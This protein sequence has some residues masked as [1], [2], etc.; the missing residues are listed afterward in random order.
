[1]KHAELS[2]HN[3]AVVINPL[4][5]Q[6]VVVVE[7]VDTTQGK[8]DAPS[9]WREAAPAA[10]M[11]STNDYFDNDRLIGDV[12]ALDVDIEVR[13]C[14]HQPL[15]KGADTADSLVVLTP[16]LIVIVRSLPKSTKDAFQIVSVFEANV[17]FD[18]GNARRK[19]VPVDR[20]AREASPHSQ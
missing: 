4:S 18:Q 7:G 17:L 3:S 14:L 8:M 13:K 9:R 12:H 10:K 20:F 15:V 2:Q 6:T 1:M 5:G 16:C 19:S 11:R